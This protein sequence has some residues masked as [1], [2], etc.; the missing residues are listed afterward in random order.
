MIRLDAGRCQIHNP[1]TMLAPILLLA[2]VVLA[3]KFA[4]PGNRFLPGFARLLATPAIVGG[5]L[6]VLSGRSEATGSHRG[7]EVVATLQLK[8]GTHGIGSF[9]VAVRTASQLTL[10]GS[11][12][13]S[14][15]RD[16]AGRLALFTLAAEDVVLSLDQRWLQ[17][18]WRPMGFM[19]FPGPFDEARWARVLDAMGTVVESL[20]R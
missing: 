2:V 1:L 10:D 18:L 11:A 6:S 19:F 15:V 8:R 20:E 3:W 16:E 5:P 7:R 13:D 12:I 9:V 14:R 17:A 4:A